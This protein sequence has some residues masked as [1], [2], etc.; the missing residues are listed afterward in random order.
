ME[1]ASPHV[2]SKRDCSD[3]LKYILDRCR[4]PAL[5]GAWEARRSE[6]HHL[7]M[8]ADVVDHGV[9][10]SPHILPTQLRKTVLM[11]GTAKPP[12]MRLQSAQHSLF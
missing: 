4:F 12:I 8:V 6:L 5:N 7:G 1:S 2:E 10:D 11:R 3:V 9:Y